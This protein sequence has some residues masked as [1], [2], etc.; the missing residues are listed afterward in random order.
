MMSS[1]W[2]LHQFQTLQPGV[3]STQTHAVAKAR[4]PNDTRIHVW[5]QVQRVE[6]SSSL[7]FE[8]C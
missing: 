6:T 2:M 5:F 4:L 8:G 3:V 1:G 7:G